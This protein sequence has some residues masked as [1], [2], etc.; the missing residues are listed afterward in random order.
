MR[1]ETSAILIGAALVA[2]LLASPANAQA[3]FAPDKQVFDKAAKDALEVG[4]SGLDCQRPDGTKEAKVIDFDQKNSLA[5]LAV[6]L[7]SGRFTLVTVRTWDRPDDPRP[8]NPVLEAARIMQGKLHFFSRMLTNDPASA[9]DE[10][11]VMTEMGGGYVCWAKPAWMM[12]AASP[13]AQAPAPKPSVSPAVVAPADA[14][15]A[16]AASATAVSAAASPAGTFTDP[17]YRRSTRA[18]QSAPSP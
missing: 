4:A 1:H 13:V 7:G 12:E 11:L 3:V 9:P 6:S 18:R 5:R 8:L 17:N 15:A 14:S 2:G 10:Y 16:A